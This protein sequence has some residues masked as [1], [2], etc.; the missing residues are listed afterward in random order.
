M[1]PGRSWLIINCVA[2]LH[3]IGHPTENYLET[4]V[5]RSESAVVDI[6]HGWPVDIVEVQVMLPSYYVFGESIG[7]ST[8]AINQQPQQQIFPCASHEAQQQRSQLVEAPALKM[9]WG[10]WAENSLVAS[11]SKQNIYKAAAAVEDDDEATR[12]MSTKTS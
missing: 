9:D 3:H 12:P 7:Q 2:I 4:V 10:W 5:P 6:Y 11:H 8:T 1:L